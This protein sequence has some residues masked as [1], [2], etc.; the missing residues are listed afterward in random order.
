VADDGVVDE[1]LR[2]LEPLDLVVERRP[3]LAQ[4]PDVVSG[5][6]VSSRPISARLS[7]MSLPRRI[8]VMR[9]EAWSAS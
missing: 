1:R 6:V 5:G 4:L 2:R 7:P 3:V 8:I 9:V